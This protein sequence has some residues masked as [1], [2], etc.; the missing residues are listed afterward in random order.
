MFYALYQ[1]EGF[2]KL[3]PLDAS[4]NRK[5]Q[6]N[7]TPPRQLQSI[8]GKQISEVIKKWEKADKVDNT[9]LGGL[10]WGLDSPAK[11]YVS[12]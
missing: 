4:N 10:D 6:L 9:G 11:Q 3:F 7:F 1:S 2:L 8:S 12:A 5:E